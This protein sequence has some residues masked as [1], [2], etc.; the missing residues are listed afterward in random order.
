M[1]KQ[2]AGPRRED[3]WRRAARGK[4]RN[5][6]KRSLQRG[7][8]DW[9]CSQVIHLPHAGDQFWEGFSLVQ[10]STSRQASPLTGNSVNGLLNAF[11]GTPPLSVTL[12]WP[13]KPHPESTFTCHIYTPLARTR[14]ASSRRMRRGEGEAGHVQLIFVAE[15]AGLL[16]VLWRWYFVLHAPYK[17]PLPLRGFQKNIFIKMAKA[18]E[19]AMFP[20]EEEG[21]GVHMSSSQH[22]SA[23]MCLLYDAYKSIKD[24]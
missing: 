8:G 1:E 5:R 7:V 6:D 18:G 24:L 13:K 19:A 14:N 23:V 22:S 3:G 2:L 9:L 4:G 16:S 10:H 15:R 21:N 12:C 20:L 17:T 11:D